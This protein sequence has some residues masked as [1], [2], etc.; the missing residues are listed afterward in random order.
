MAEQQQNQGRPKNALDEFKLRLTAPKLEN[1]DRPPMLAISVVGN[2]PRINVFTNVPSDKNRGIIRAA[3]DT[4]MMYVLIDLLYEMVDA[5]PETKKYID[6]YT[7]NRG[8]DGKNKTECESRTVVG[9]DK[10]GIVYLSVISTDESRPR[11]KFNFQNSYYH[12]VHDGQGNQLEKAD[13][14]RRM[15]RAYANMLS[16]LVANVLDTN[17]QQPQQQGGFG[18]GN[19]GG[20]RGGQSGG[21]G[22]QKQQA[23]FSGGSGDD[24]DDDIPL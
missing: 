6:N 17:Y 15:A 12:P 7:R 20:N 3:M 18:G 13:M 14:S 2:H 19:R 9:K 22:G 8:E 11:V 23:D 4:P 24:W 1:G 5:E 21:G 16:N 10:N